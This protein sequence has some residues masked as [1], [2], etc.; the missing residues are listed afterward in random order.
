MYVLVCAMNFSYLKE[1]K[2]KSFVYFVCFFIVPGVRKIAKT[3]TIFGKFIVNRVQA[4]KFLHFIRLS[5]SFAYSN[6]ACICVFFLYFG[7][8]YIE[9]IKYSYIEERKKV[10]NIQKPQEYELFHWSNGVRIM[11]FMRDKWGEEIKWINKIFGVVNIFFSHFERD[12]EENRLKYFAHRKFIHRNKYYSMR[13]I[14]LTKK[15]FTLIN[16]HAHTRCVRT[17]QV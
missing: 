7:S 2:R 14:F 16:S 1:C 3:W 10:G 5:G 8:P 4:D 6:W 15:T 11:D 13:D 12:N 9:V 17:F